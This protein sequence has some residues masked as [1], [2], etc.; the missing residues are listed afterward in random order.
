MKTG[1][2]NSI[3]WKYSKDELIKML[4]SSNSLVGVLKS[5]GLNAYGRNAHT[6]KKIIVERGINLNEYQIRYKKIQG[7]KSTE[8]LLNCKFHTIPLSK[9]LVE[10]KMCSSHSLKK[11]LYKEGILEEVCSNCGVSNEWAGNPISLHLDHI[12]GIHD[13]N[14]IENLRILCPNCHSQTKTYAG[15]ALKKVKVCANCETSNT[16]KYSVYC[17]KCYEGIRDG[18][19]SQGKFAT[20]TV[21]KKKR[22]CLKCGSDDTVNKKDYCKVCWEEMKKETAIKKGLSSRKFNATKEELYKLIWEDK[23]PYR[24]IGK[25]YNV[26]DNAIKKRCKVLGVPLRRIKTQVI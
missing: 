9:M 16:T 25:L 26:S 19:M 1:S 24:H 4:E 3:M 5:I 12:N 10:N 23:L 18:R 15:K 6:L 22:L 2:R 8:R 14:R 11:R 13:D 20:G 21:R 7:L 17:K